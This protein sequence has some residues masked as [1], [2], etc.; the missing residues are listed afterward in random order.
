MTTQPGVRT[1]GRRSCLAK[2]PRGDGGEYALPFAVPTD[3]IFKGQKR[4]QISSVRQRGYQT[5]KKCNKAVRR[6]E[7]NGYMQLEFLFTRSVYALQLFAKCSNPK[8][9]VFKL[10]SAKE[11]IRQKFHQIANQKMRNEEGK[12]GRMSA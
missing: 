3:V 7:K 2:E 5:E 9:R 11:I 10:P 1:T 8:I 12:K 4:K 6:E